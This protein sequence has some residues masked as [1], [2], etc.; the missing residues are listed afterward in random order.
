MNNNNLTDAVMTMN[1]DAINFMRAKEY[2]SA[3][4]LLKQGIAWVRG[5][6]RGDRAITE[7]FEG[8]DFDPPKLELQAIE[9]VEQSEFSPVEIYANAIG[10]VSPAMIR[11]Q[12][13][14]QLLEQHQREGGENNPTMNH[15]IMQ[16]HRAQQRMVMDDRDSLS[17]DPRVENTSALLSCIL[18]YNLGLC[19]QLAAEQGRRRVDGTLRM[20]VGKYEAA[21]GIA[22]LLHHANNINNNIHGGLAFSILKLAILNNCF[23][24]HYHFVKIQEAQICLDQM[25]QTMLGL[26]NHVIENEAPSIQFFFS[27]IRHNIQQHTRASPSA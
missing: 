9:H 10:I 17:S 14:Q 7:R 23:H 27:N 19:F 2:S 13:L 1:R 26:P 16:H 25:Q 21:R 24:I 11:Q 4:G 6:I 15:I 8:G 22:D 12:Q 18:I 20:A 5:Y 3:S